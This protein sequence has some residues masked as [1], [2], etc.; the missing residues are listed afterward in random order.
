MR[1]GRTVLM[2]RLDKTI[3][4]EVTMIRGKRAPSS[5]RLSQVAMET[6]AWW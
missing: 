2:I 4:C 6:V 1:E 3:V 5:V